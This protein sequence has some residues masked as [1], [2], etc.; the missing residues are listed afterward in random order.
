[1]D[2]VAPG[3]AER[4]PVKEPLQTGIKAIDS[5][6]PDRP[7]SARTDSRRPQDGQDRDRRGRHPEPEGYW[8]KVFYVAIGQKES[9]VAGVVEILRNMARWKYTTVIV[10]S[11]AFSAPFQYVAA[12]AGCAMPS[13]SCGKAAHAGGIR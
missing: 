5:N 4:Q 11:A 13:T 8:R 6:D 2:I 9:S 12:Y 3:I 7:G 1:M 10:A